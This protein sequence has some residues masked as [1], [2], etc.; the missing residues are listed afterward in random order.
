MQN[1]ES[2]VNI[3]Q[4]TPKITRFIHTDDIKHDAGDGGIKADQF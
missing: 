2:L 3:H 1:G 4:G